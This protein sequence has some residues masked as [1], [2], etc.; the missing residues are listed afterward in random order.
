MA[1]WNRFCALLFL[2]TSPLA[3]V[4]NAETEYVYGVDA[5]GVTRPLALE[6]Y[7]A[8]Y[9]GDFGDCLGGESLFNI[10]KFDAA[11]YADNLTIVFHL[12]GTSNIRNESLMMHIEV[13]AYGSN[14]F[15]M[16]FDPCNLNLYSLCPLNASV[17]VKG[18]A[19]I[20]V[21]PQQ[22]GGIPPVAFAIPDIEG[23]AK[24]Q[25]FANSSQTEI[26]CFQAN[27][28]NGNSFSHPEAVAPVL[29]VFTLVAI[30][31]SFATAA[32]GVSIAHMRMHYAHSLSVFIVFETFQSIFFTGALSVNWPSVCIAWWS[33]FAWSAGIIYAPAMVHSIDS[34]AGVKGNAS[35]V[36]GAGSVVINNNGG[37]INQIYG[38]SI[39][40]RTTGAMLRR[41]EYNAS[42][43]Y[44]YTWAGNPVMPG[45]PTPGTWSGFP[46][47][48]AGAGIPAADAFL[49][50]FIWIVV[51][52]GVVALSIA[53]LKGSLE[54]LARRKWIKE[55]RLAYFR[56]HWA[57][58]L[59]LSVVRAFFMAFFAV[60]TLSMFQFSMSGPS[61]MMAVSA[62]VFII[63]LAGAT[64][65]V[66]YACRDRTRYGRFQTNPD[67]VVFHSSKLFKAVPIVIP[68][69]SSTLKEREVQVQPV[70]TIPLFRIRHVNDDP[71]RKTVHQDQG[72]IK[73]YGWLSARYRRTRWWFL[74]YYI[75]YLTVRAAFL[76]GGIKSPLAQVYGLLIFEILAFAAI[77]ILNPFEGA[78]NTAMAVWMLS[79]NK[80]VTTGLSIAFLPAF[81]L[82]RI[83]ATV[84]G[85]IIIVIQ[86]LVVVALLILIVLS[87]ISSWMSLSR[88]RE[89][90]GSEAL[91][92]IRVR[93]FNSMEAKAADSYV[94]P[95]SGKGKD[96]EDGESPQ[97]P[98]KPYFSVVSV[99]R[100]PKIEDEDDDVLY[101]L[102]P[103]QHAINGVDPATFRVSSRASRTNSV[104]SR[105]STSSLPRAGRAHN[106]SWSSKDF[107]QMDAS[108][109]Q[110]DSGLAQR[111]SDM[112]S[113]AGHGRDD[114]ASSTPVPFT[115]RPASSRQ[116]L[117][118][119]SGTRP[120]S[121]FS[122]GLN[123]PSRE[124]LARHAE[125]RRYPTPKPGV[126]DLSEE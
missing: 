80:I 33:N 32:Y 102:E 42:N 43:P 88:N 111:L 83:I 53:V 10:T 11:Y 66:A 75:G 28:R 94:P 65:L 64:L 38:R 58:Y 104:S 81:N 12:D 13:D 45:M 7:P 70:F 34:F 29:G 50:G 35:Q 27:M 24:L 46:A 9:T 68:A 124:T 4:A 47:T 72:Y 114:S 25:I 31:A 120:I 14:R 67:E 26:G 19:S 57:G 93:Y 90:M 20:Q 78:R 61:G 91:E 89:D 118:T 119:L 95:K 105:Y 125:E 87:A 74:A 99:R 122:P 103:P 60:M 85:V 115:V 1:P 48:L 116:S 16:T 110:T 100:A 107:A 5:E 37:L 30:V 123:T 106:S 54:V 73:K 97:E 101:D 121:P 49:V 40:P 126:P 113:S 3:F 55:D 8:L 79:I 22:I 52:M 17:P 36:G 82:D 23:F 18:W 51:A 44:D 41:S 2:L 6:R 39:L 62:V 63:F 15:E 59:G 77:I 109:D 69:W 98:P 92:P 96:K 112:N 71:A 56:D 117:R 84:I 21:G 76:G 86:G 108:P